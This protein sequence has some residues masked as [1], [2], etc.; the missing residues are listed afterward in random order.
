MACMIENVFLKYISSKNQIPGQIM[1]FLTCRVILGAAGREAPGIQGDAGEVQGQGGALPLRLPQ[2]ERRRRQCQ[3]HGRRHALRPAVEQHAVRD[4]RGV[5]AVHVR[6]LPG[7]GRRGDGDLRRRRDG[8]RRRGGGAAC[9]GGVGVGARGGRGV[10]SHG[11]T[12]SLIP[13]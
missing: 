6:R 9:Q 1:C 11:R 5:P 8:G 13:S 10:D 2:Q 7:R 12:G 3:P 4:Q